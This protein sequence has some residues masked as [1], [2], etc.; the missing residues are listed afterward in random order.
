MPKSI[1]TGAYPAARMR[2]V[3]QFDWARRLVRESKPSPDDLVWG[4]DQHRVG[5]FDIHLKREGIRCRR[6]TI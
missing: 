4:R 5:R 2:R 6:F 3:R 1:I